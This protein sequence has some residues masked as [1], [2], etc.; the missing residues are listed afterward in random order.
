M[1]NGFFI[2]AG[3]ADGEG[4]SNSLF[5]ELKRNVSQ[6]LN[7]WQGC[8][9]VQEIRPDPTYWKFFDEMHHD[10]QLLAKTFLLWINGDTLKNINV[11]LSIFRYFKKFCVVKHL[12]D[13]E[14]CYNTKHRKNKWRGRILSE[15]IKILWLCKKI[16]LNKIFCSFDIY[17][18]SRI[19]HRKVWWPIPNFLNKVSQF[20]VI[21]WYFTLHSMLSNKYRK[22]EIWLHFIIFSL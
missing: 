22:I 21:S 5:L 8:V 20:Y 15:L 17:V 2:E 1:E 19:S 14:I 10:M 12:N 9:R 18:K 3:A 7:T 4:Y 13:S 16:A 6:Y 11:T